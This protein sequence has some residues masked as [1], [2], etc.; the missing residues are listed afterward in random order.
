MSDTGRVWI[1]VVP[2]HGSSATPIISFPFIA[3]I[4]GRIIRRRNFGL[5]SVLRRH[6][7]I[8]LP[9]KVKDQLSSQKSQ[10]AFLADA[11]SSDEE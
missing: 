9:A 5:P 11:Q 8:E 1:D 10:D 2:V 4:D 6:G 3:A 7:E